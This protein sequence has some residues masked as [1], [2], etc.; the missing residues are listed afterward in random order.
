M[1]ER[2]GRSERVIGKLLVAVSAVLWVLG[3]VICLAAF[4]SGFWMVWQLYEPDLSFTEFLD[5]W[6]AGLALLAPVAVGAVR[7]RFGPSI[8]EFWQRLQESGSTRLCTLSLALGVMVIAFVAVAFF[9]PATLMERYRDAVVAYQQDTAQLLRDRIKAKDRFSRVSGVVDAIFEF[10]FGGRGFGDRARYLRAQEAAGR[11]IPIFEYCL[12]SAEA[13]TGNWAD[14]YRHFENIGNRDPQLRVLSYRDL[15]TCFELNGR[16]RAAVVWLLRGREELDRTDGT[17]NRQ[18]V[19][20]YLGYVR[21]WF[22]ENLARVYLQRGKLEMSDSCMRYARDW[23]Q[24]SLAD[25]YL[26]CGELEKSEKAWRSLA[27]RIEG[28][29]NCENEELVQDRL[30]VVLFYENR[31]GMDSSLDCLS[32]A[33]RCSDDAVVRLRLAAVHIAAGQI[34]LA[35]EKLDDPCVQKEVK[36]GGQYVSRLC[37]I[38]RDVADYKKTRVVPRHGVSGQELV[39]KLRNDAVW[40]SSL[41]SR[42]SFGFEAPVAMALQDMARSVKDGRLQD[43]PSLAGYHGRLHLNLLS[44][45]TRSGPVT[46]GRVRKRPQQHGRHHVQ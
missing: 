44:A 26:E 4:A 12:L 34:Q 3:S 39:R 22:Q 13:H 17:H 38:L 36:G 29:R 2:N 35:K 23:Y 25:A 18:D 33:E 24:E 16:P 8:G 1:G 19:V 14:A 28:G 10:Q 40:L 31:H 32:K 9:R 27:D 37:A 45:D 41:Q 5:T 20:G 42:Q 46:K 11:D 30:G 7:F 6:K 15:A 21:G 43:W